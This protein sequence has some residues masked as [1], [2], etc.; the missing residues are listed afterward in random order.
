ML[1]P[2]RKLPRASFALLVVSLACAASA[3]LVMRAYAARLDAARP[4]G[5]PP[6]QVVVA[7]RTITRGA[8]IAPDAVRAL[9]M[10]SRFVPPGALRDPARAAGRVATADVAAGEV[11][12][13]LRLAGGDT[14]RIAALVPPG[15]RAVH[16]AVAA[17]AGAEP[18]D[19]VDVL[20]TFGG[21]A[22]HTETVAEAVEVLALRRDDGGPLGGG[23][24]TGGL[25][26]VVL[27]EPDEAE[28]LAFATA[29]ATLSIAIRGPA[30]AVEA[31][32][33][34]PSPTP[35]SG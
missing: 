31:Q 28:R 2:R 20:A 30:D 18:G 34:F 9:T 13:R 10:P 35:A 17:G 27:V 29:F 4:D 7:T 22:T 11:V 21:G 16:L 1:L 6:V 24:V 3:A 25:G 15:M 19:H 14:G 33:S 32:A 12:T 5:G 26:L 8:T 23:A